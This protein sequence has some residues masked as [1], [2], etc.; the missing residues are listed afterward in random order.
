MAKRILIVEDDAALAK[1]LADNLSLD[2]FVVEWSA[3]GDDAPG[4]RAR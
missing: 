3:S 2:G 1:V 4:R